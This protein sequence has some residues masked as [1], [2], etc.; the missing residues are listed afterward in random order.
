MNIIHQLGLFKVLWRVV[1]PRRDVMP[2]L[3]PLKTQLSHVLL[4]K[5]GS[6]YTRAMAL[7]GCLNY[8]SRGEIGICLLYY[9]KTGSG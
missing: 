9:V 1:P 6:G 2:A 7:T 8:V 4:I 3:S 5:C